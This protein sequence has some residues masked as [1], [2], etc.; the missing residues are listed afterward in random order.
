M[1]QEENAFPN[2]INISFSFVDGETIVILL[3]IEG[4]CVSAGSACNAGQSITSHVIEAIGLTGSLARGTVPFLPFPIQ[5]E[6]IDRTVDA[7]KKRN[8]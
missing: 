6:E 5:K 3:D 7:L 1:V 2:N 4:I 8:N